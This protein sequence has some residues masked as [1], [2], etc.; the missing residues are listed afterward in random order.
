[1]KRVIKFFFK[2][3]IFYLELCSQQSGNDN[4]HKINIGCIA[5]SGKSAEKMVLQQPDQPYAT[6]SLLTSFYIVSQPDVL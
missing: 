6:R 4:T 5:K 2:G 3:L 1:M